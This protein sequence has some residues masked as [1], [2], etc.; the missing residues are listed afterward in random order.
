M[1]DFLTVVLLSLACFL[2]AYL[3]IPL[4][5]HLEGPCYPALRT[6]LIYPPALVPKLA[7]PPETGD[8]VRPHRP[9]VR[10]SWLATESLFERPRQLEWEHPE[11]Y[12]EVKQFYG[13]DPARCA[14]PGTP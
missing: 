12:A 13:Q 4:L 2:G 1:S 9:L 6:V 8:I 7:R 5:L 10:E 14:P 3:V 11:L